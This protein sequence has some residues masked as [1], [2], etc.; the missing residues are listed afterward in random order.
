[1]ICYLSFDQHKFHSIFS[2]LNWQIIFLNLPL[3]LYCIF[4]GICIVFHWHILYVVQ[5]FFPLW[6]LLII[7][8]LFQEDS[9]VFLVIWYQGDI[10]HNEVVR[11]ELLTYNILLLI[12][13]NDSYLKDLHWHILYH[14]PSFHKLEDSRVY[15]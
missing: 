3:I 11:G 2:C 1:M 5:I 13:Q 7:Y 15:Q 6:Y 8:H 9:L 12:H 14:C 10:E 4:E